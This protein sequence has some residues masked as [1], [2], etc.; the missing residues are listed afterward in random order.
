MQLN[1]EW[2]VLKRYDQQHLRRIALPL[3]GIGTGTVSLGGRGNLQDWEIVNRPAKGFTPMAVNN[4]YGV[5]PFFA[6]YARQAG[7]KQ[8]VARCLEGPIDTEFYEGA[9]GAR[10]PTHGLPRFEQCEFAAAYPLGQV[11]LRDKA[12]PVDVRLEAFNP[13]TPADA[14]TSGQP[15]AVLR[16]TLTNRT[17]K[18]VTASIAGSVVNFIGEDGFAREQNW[19][20]SQVPA[21]AKE[22]RNAFRKTKKLQGLF[23]TTQGVPG[24]RETWGT[25]AL[26]TT[27]SSG[28]TYRTAWKQ[29]GWGGPL[30]D[31]WDDLTDDG[32]LD[33]RPSG[34]GVDKPI[35]SL[36]VK[37]TVPAGK[38]KTITF[39]LGWHFPNRMTW[40]PT[41]PPGSSWAKPDDKKKKKGTS[42]P[43]SSPCCEGDDC[44]PT[45]SDMSPNWVGNYYATQ[46][47]DAWDA[48][49][50]FAGRL[51]KDEA[52][53]VA[54]VKAV[55]E[56]DLPEVVRES[57]LFNVS[58][59]RSQT[60][61]RTADG[62]F[63]G[64]EG[65]HDHAGCCHGSCTH[66]W[67][68][69][70][71]TAFLFGAIARDMREIELLHA[72][73]VD[74]RM[75]FRVNLPLDRALEYKAVAADGQMGVLMKLYR[76]WR[77]SG[78][79]AMLDRLWPAAK[80]ALAFCWIPHGWD[81]DVDGVMEGCQHNTMDV[82]YF[83][84]NPQMQLWYLGALRAMEEMAR[85]QGDEAFAEKCRELFENGRAFAD[86]KL[87][88]GDYYEHLIQPP[89]EPEKIPPSL[90]HGMGAK[91]LRNPDNQ[92]G[93]G[94]LIDQLVGQYMADVCGLGYLT[95]PANVRKTLRSVMKFNFL[96][97]F[98]G[99]A[100]VMRTYVL[101]DE[102][103][104]LMASYPRGDR[105]ELP[106]SYFTEVMTGFEYTAATH[107]LF[108]GQTAAGLKAIAAIRDRYDGFKRNPFNEAECGHHYARAM[109]A[110]T[111]VLALTGFHYDAVDQ[112]MAFASPEK[113]ATWFW[114]TGNAYGS[115]TLTPG[116]KGTKAELSVLGGE[117]SLKRLSL[118]NGQAVELPRGKTLKAGQSLRETLK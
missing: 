55:C 48:A 6:I 34:Q 1:P 72:T 45:E 19:T 95:K 104:M 85:H 67:N 61:F 81:G 32:N 40:T 96:P 87:F 113:K 21:G 103:A 35:G 11:L 14:D 92:I 30:L 10:T 99:H 112:A 71:T 53:T 86:E 41:P 54:F 18:S 52:A 106:F 89:A 68:Y 47:R 25:M 50:T 13:L 60:C 26:G 59:L 77:L 98:K 57:A 66:V 17:Q 8:G 82:E 3:G 65:C 76:D 64:F 58:T 107:M 94:C 84:P 2:P 51:K 75:P 114:S 15:V 12:V 116:K 5:G 74:G 42:L 109:A 79:N 69:E 111:G 27:A 28:V 90:I 83:G 23:M 115:A 63:F 100:N 78:D 105:P 7:E 62:H 46:Y 91:D 108:E 44:C 73:D 38:S 33:N 39:I 16:Y 24:D 9:H 37:T 80:R 49:N 31:F 117:V 70:Q 4:A 88:N 20:G 101:N 97:S 43:V 102:A 118:K 93:A 56:S 110:W 36:C 22:N 29:A